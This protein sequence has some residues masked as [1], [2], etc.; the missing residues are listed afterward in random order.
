[1]DFKELKAS[2]NIIDVVAGYVDLKK[3]G[4]EH[5]G[6]CPFHEDHKGSLNV[7][8]GKQIFKCFAC[9][10]GGD[11]VDFLIS[12]GKTHKEAFEEL[13]G[14]GGGTSKPKLNTVDR[15]KRIEWKRIAPES[16]PDSFTHY[17]LGNP[18]SKWLY[19]NAD[20]SPF[21]YILRFESTKGKQTLPYCFATDGKRKEWRFLG[22]G[23]NRPIYNLHL[24]AKYQ[25]STIL[26]VE[27]EKS[28]EA[29]QA[30][31]DPSKL[32]VTTWHGGG[33]AVHKADFSHLKN[34]RV[35]LWPDN[36]AVG[37]GAMMHILHLIECE[38]KLLPLNESLPKGWDCADKQWAEGEIRQYIIANATQPPEIGQTY[39]VKEIGRGVIYGMGMS[40]GRWQMKER[41]TDEAEEPAKDAPAKPSKLDVPAVPPIPSKAPV[42]AEIPPNEGD[43]DPISYEQEPF[44]FCGYDKSES[45]HQNFY[46]YVYLSNQIVRLS[47][48]SMTKSNLLMLAPL[49]WWEEM[50][51]TKSGGVNTDMAQNY[52]VQTSIT[53]GI[54]NP[55]NARGRGCW[56]D[57]K[58][59]LM[60]VGSHLIV[61]G[62]GV[63]FSEYKSKYHYEA[64][65]D[66]EISLGLAAN[67]QQASKF[68]DLCNFLNWE[69]PIYGYLLAGWCVIAPFCGALDW[70]P[71]I[72][73]T[74]GAG[75]GKSWIFNNIIRKMLGK[76]VLSVQ[77]ESTS[78]GIRQWMGSDALPIIFD[79]AEGEGKADHARMQGVLN[80]MRGSS[81]TDGGDIVKGSANGRPDKYKT[82]SCMAFA[83]IG[84]QITQESDKGRISVLSAV[85]NPDSIEKKKHYKELLAKLRETM[86]DDFPDRLKSRTIDILPNIL[87]NA[88]IFIEASMQVFGDQ[89]TSDQIGTLLA[90]AYSLVSSKEISFEKAL[91]WIES[92]DW[93]EETDKSDA[94]DETRLINFLMERLTYVEV[95]GMK[96]ERTIGELV[97]IAYEPGLYSSESITEDRA[98]ERLLRLGY[99]VDKLNELLI[100]S[101]TAEPI[102]TALRDTPW[103]NNHG[104]ILK[105]LNGALAVASTTFGAHTKSRAVSIPMQ[106]IF[107]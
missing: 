49:D 52:L 34:R 67:N 51:P 8:E 57:G 106:T 18:S 41:K 42:P 83:S 66:L 20:G 62:H 85:K 19:R 86:K 47:P 40:D 26:I 59:V 78:A 35:F 64:S 6:L 99:R 70:R 16:P 7:N 84:V 15:P 29:A 32:V 77:G 46:F 92:K 39:E 54:F 9:G 38:A 28:A 75:S 76:T 1:M 33:N 107:G 22:F 100:V 71:H 82:K 27:G 81:T 21:G 2:V 90:G 104:N 3:Q 44:R 43:P 101:N 10:E 4:R 30:H 79:E 12:M 72:W 60:H 96:L 37:W 93:A 14:A 94:A 95:G 25:E 103:A 69:R 5:V 63:P 13:G 50:F 55:D 88:S 11:A 61:N 87:K 23:E 98:K 65:T 74:G 80:L 36:D 56:V 53:K 45:G 68:L 105:R 48:S 89:R 97:K 24:I 73:I 17:T 58:D 31:F 102:R 91:Q